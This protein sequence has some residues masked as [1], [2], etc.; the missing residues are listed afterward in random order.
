MVI[1]SSIKE[2]GQLTFA[3]LPRAGDDESLSIPFCCVHHAILGKEAKVSPKIFLYTNI[4]IKKGQHTREDHALKIEDGSLHC[5]DDFASYHLHVLVQG[6]SH[7]LFS[8]KRILS[9]GLF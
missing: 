6:I 1:S 5:Q 2:R 3:E 9:V 8:G 4:R 7:I